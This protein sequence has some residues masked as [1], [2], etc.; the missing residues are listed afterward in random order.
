MLP[1]LSPAEAYRRA[2]FDALVA[3]GDARQLTSLCLAE[4]AGSVALA[5]LWHERGE[6]SRRAAALTRALFC[7]HALQ[8]GVDR[9]RPLGEALLIVYRDLAARISGAL[10]RYDAEQVRDAQRDL[11]EIDRAFAAA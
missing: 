1:V 11:R 10:C 7:L 8:R 3:S 9:S 6:A 5:M 2:A 4:A